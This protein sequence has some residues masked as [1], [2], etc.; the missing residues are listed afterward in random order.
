MKRRLALIAA[1]AS[2]WLVAAVAVIVAAL[3]WDSVPT[4]AEWDARYREGLADCEDA[5]AQR[6][7][8]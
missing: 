2:G 1:I 5:A 3:L 4:Q 7:G 6:A 8:A